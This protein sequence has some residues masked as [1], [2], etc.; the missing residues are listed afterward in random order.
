MNFILPNRSQWRTLS[1]PFP[2]IIISIYYLMFYNLG[3]DLTHSLNLFGLVFTLGILSWWLSVVISNCMNWLLPDSEQLPLRA[4]CIFLSQLSI[5]IVIVSILFQALDRVSQPGRLELDQAH[6]VAAL[7]L[8]LLSNIIFNS[9]WQVRYIFEHWKNALTTKELLDQEQL[10][11]EYRGLREQLHP[12]F[13]FDSLYAVGRLIANDLERSITYL[14]VLSKVYRAFLNENKKELCSLSQEFEHV[15]LYVKLLETANGMPIRLDISPIG[16]HS[17][18]YLPP[19]S[20]QRIIEDVK[21]YHY[22]DPNLPEIRIWTEEAYVYVEHGL[23]AHW[24]YT[25]SAN[26]RSIVGRYNYLKIGQ[27]SVKKNGESLRYS[28]P[29]QVK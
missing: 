17:A 2:I 18:H 15:M 8:A 27:F 5:E 28:L 6:F 26:L 19:F 12:Y 22:P 11:R 1:F 23:H 25:P 4:L 16:E 13:L 24:N 3:M 10:L 21:D 9:I 29:L 7:V 14:D 20:I